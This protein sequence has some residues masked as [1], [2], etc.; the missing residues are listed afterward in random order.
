[1]TE[2]PG[3]E[4]THSAVIVPVPA[5]E[6]L[7][8]RYRQRLDPA[9]AWGVGAH[10]TVLFPFAPPVE[11]DEELVGRLAG[12]VADVPRFGCAFRRCAWFGD[13]VLWLAPEPDA[14]FRRLVERV[15]AAFPDHP[16]YGGEFA[17]VVPHL[18]V[19][20]VEAGSADALRS[21][22]AELAPL[23]PIETQVDHVA[24][25]AGAEAP[26]SWRTVVTLPLGR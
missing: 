9:A 6:P 10:V 12:A 17:E 8:G 23:L 26:D 7:V 5:A 2:C 15:T 1:M 13:A 20:H 3:P 25:I 18:T 4:A 22:E 21:A 16:P 24:L 19:G 11:L 14:G